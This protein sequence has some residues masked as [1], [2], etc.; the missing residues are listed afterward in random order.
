ML[1]CTHEF[2]WEVAAVVGVANVGAAVLSC[3]NMYVVRSGCCGLK[4]CE[5][6]VKVCERVM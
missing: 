2:G 3:A 4:V 1:S 6:V 5:I